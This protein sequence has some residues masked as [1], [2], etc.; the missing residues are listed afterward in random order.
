MHLPRLRSIRRSGTRL[1]ALTCSCKWM[2]RLSRWTQWRTSWRA[3]RKSGG[4]LKLRSSRWWHRWRRSHLLMLSNA[5]R[6]MGSSRWSTLRKHDWSISI[7]TW[8]IRWPDNRTCRHR[9]GREC[10]WRWRSWSQTTGLR[11]WRPRWPSSSH[12]RRN[13]ALHW[14]SWRWN[15][16]RKARWW[17][18]RE[19]NRRCTSKWGWRL[20]RRNR[21]GRWW[22][23]WGR[24]RGR[25]GT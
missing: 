8:Q 20:E 11:E 19:R 24:K 15:S 12:I 23:R 5:C 22:E 16:S 2:R 18:A 6:K 1:H 3:P 7:R 14:A 10:P 21:R 9:R 17:W 4:T 13:A 25:S